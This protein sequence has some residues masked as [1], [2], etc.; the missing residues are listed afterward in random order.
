MNVILRGHTTF[1]SFDL[2]SGT[3]PQDL[4]IAFYR[5]TYLQH[6]HTY[7]CI[8][9]KLLEKAK[10]MESTYVLPDRLMIHM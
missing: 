6:D 3:A 1:C 5:Y 7:I 10:K 4:K 2:L 9:F 8:V